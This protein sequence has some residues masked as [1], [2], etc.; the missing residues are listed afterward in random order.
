MG[1][2][3]SESVNIKA[4]SRCL[5]MPSYSKRDPSVVAPTQRKRKVMNE[6]MQTMENFLSSQD[7]VMQIYLTRGAPKTSPAIGEVAARMPFSGHVTRMTESEIVSV[8]SI[9]LD[10]DLFLRHHTLG[11]RVSLT[12]K[13]LMSLPVMP[14]SM[15]LEI[16]AETASQL[17]PQKHLTA[18]KNVCVNRWVSMEEK[19]L[20]LETT[21]RVLNDAQKDGVHVQLGIP[22]TG[23]VME[24]TMV[25]RDSYPEAPSI[26]EL[27]LRSEKK[28]D[29]TPEKFYPEAL[30]HGPSLRIVKSLDRIGDD[31]VEAMLEVPDGRDLFKGMPDPSLVA[32][33]MLLDGMGQV[34]GLWASSCLENGFVIFPAGL[35]ELEFYAQ[36]HGSSE[37]LT[38]R[39][40]TTLEG[41]SY[42]HSDV[43]AAGPGGHLQM[44]IKGLKHKRV[45]MPEIF[46]LFRGSRDV[47]LS[48]SW[49][50]PAERLSS[51]TAV[52]CCRLD[53][54]PLEFLETD[55]GIW[56]TVLA[57]IVLS[58]NEREVFRN[59]QGSEKRKSE[60]LLARVAGKDA[61]RFLMRN[62]YG[63]D[64]WPAD[65]EIN[66]DEHG[67]PVVR[68]DDALYSDY[69]PLLSLSHKNGVSVALAADSRKYS[70]I[71]IDIEFYKPLRSGFE[72]IAFSPEEQRLISEVKVTDALEWQL[73]MW[74]AKEAMGKALGRGLMGNPRNI[75]VCELDS[76]NEILSLKLS[77]KMI[78]EFPGLKEKL[79]DVYSLRVN[80][81]IVA[82]QSIQNKGFSEKGKQ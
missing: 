68:I 19:S 17:M 32:D 49:K 21:A 29:L 22:E 9:N 53:Q 81:L 59:L 80:E 43:Q 30:F 72:N 3:D 26:E 58:R 63:I 7:E 69:M 2:N 51:D 55:S 71:G 54:I 52:E 18:I 10:R 36:P 31:G 39:I 35:G 27:P 82:V 5:K 40:R 20:T 67:K 75:T 57:F 6:Y 42:I 34:V 28:P 73:R 65:I 61:I 24:G 60:W 12:D 1:N 70:G 64:L 76:D 13:S 78:E 56:R 77:G 79:F 15:S 47:M 48:T 62:C 11:G 74:C 46:H 66:S 14:F 33:P 38:C 23:I 41:E 16:M 50:E 8:C 44:R 45:H 37:Q 25:F 4:D